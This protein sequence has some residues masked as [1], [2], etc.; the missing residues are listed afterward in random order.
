M[1]EHRFTTPI[2]E[3]SRRLRMGDIV[4]I[5]GTVITARDAAHRRALEILGR[6]E[7]L[8]VDFKGMAVYHM[9]PVVK[10]V[11]D[12]WEIVSAGPTT[13]TRLETYEADFLEKTGAKIVIGKGGMGPKTAEACRRLGTAYAIYTGGAGALAAKS[14]RKVKGVEWL[15]LGSP[16]ALWILEVE[17]FGP[18]TVIIDPEG[19]N[20]YDEVRAKAKANLTEA[21][22]MMG[23]TV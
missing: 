13:S 22:K 16:E 12:K 11:G 20:F 23:I 3:E 9:G 2:G 15:D 19:R 10:K 14:V 1:V 7:K 18:L 4:Y 17:D 8:P 5:T 21:Y 6:G